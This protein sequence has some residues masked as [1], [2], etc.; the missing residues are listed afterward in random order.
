[1]ACPPSV[2][3]LRTGPWRRPAGPGC[4]WEQPWVALSRAPCPAR[5]FLSSEAHC[6]P[7]L[8][9][10]GVQRFEAREKIVL[11]LRDRGLFRGL[12]EHP[13]VLPICR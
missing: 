12:R 4:R 10:Q 3:L 6:F 5:T 13:M 8:P 11:A 7:S 2:S 9:P 1:M